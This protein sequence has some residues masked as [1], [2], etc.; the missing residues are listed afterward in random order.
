MPQP[1][2]ILFICLGNICRS[3]L[4][5][6]VMRAVLLERFPDRE[7]VID[8]AG[9]NGYHTGEAPDDR[10]I[11]VAARHGEDISVQGCRQLVT[12]DFYRFNLILGMDQNNLM[13]INRHAPSDASAVTGLFTAVARDGLLGSAS[14]RGAEIPDPYYGGTAEFDMAYRMVRDA[15]E[16]LAEKLT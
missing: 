6:G 10:A 7:F 2:S 1:F 4:A 8:S 13:T 15:A 12:D 14:D 11:E 5:E 9:T 16:A 3:P